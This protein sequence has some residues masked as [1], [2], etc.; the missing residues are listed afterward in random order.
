MLAR[1]IQNGYGNRHSRSGLAEQAA[2]APSRVVQLSTTVLVLTRSQRHPKLWGALFPQSVGSGGWVL[3][4]DG[5]AALLWSS[6]GFFAELGS[7]CTR[8]EDPSHFVRLPQDFS[9][10]EPDEL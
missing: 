4:K 2:I 3:T 1:L 5:V 10:P 7:H 6:L 9:C 8:S